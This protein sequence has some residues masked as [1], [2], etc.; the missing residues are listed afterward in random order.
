MSGGNGRIDQFNIKR[1][2]ADAFQ[3]WHEDKHLATLTREE[4]WPIMMGRVHP[5]AILRDHKSKTPNKE[6]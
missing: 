3:L 4:A 5:D 2:N 1:I 6:Q